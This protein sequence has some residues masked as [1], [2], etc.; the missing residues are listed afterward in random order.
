MMTLKYTCGLLLLISTGAAA[1][2]LVKYVQPMAG[3]ASATTA[4][5]LKHGS[6]L[7]NFANTIPAVTAP[8][9]MT[10]WT[11]QTQRTESKCIPPYYHK[12][13][14]FSGFRGSHWLSGS[15]TQD[16]GSFT[17]MPIT[18]H[19]KTNNYTASFTHAD[20]ESTP[21]LYKVNLKQYQL[22]GAVTATKRCGMMQ[23]TM[24]KADSLYLLIT[25]N[26]DYHEGFIK[27][28]Q[29]KGEIYGYNPAH[30]IYQGWGKPAGFSGYFV[31][32]FERSLSRTG[33]FAGDKIFAVDS[34]KNGTTIGAYA[35]F[36][37]NKG[38]QLIIRIGTSFT[39]IDGA[40]KNLQAEI[41]AFNFDAVA[42]AG[43]ATWEK[44]LSQI[45]VNTTN[46]RDKHIFYTAY[47]HTMQQPRLFNDVDG[48]YPRFSSSYKNEKLAK[49]NYYDD[50]SMWDIYRAEIPLFEILKPKL[51]NNLVQSLILK[52][53]QGGWM[54]I[55]PCWNSY[56]S[57][58]IGDHTTSVI[59]S[60][61]LKGIRDYDVNEAYQILRH[62]AFDIP[63]SRADYVEG[64]GRRA[65]DSYLK[66]K[67]IPLEDS[68]LDAFHKMEQVSRTLEYA[69]D[70]YAL[71]QFA[72][73]LKK[74][75]DYNALSARAGYYKNVFDGKSGFVRGKLIN[76]S[77]A[78]PFNPDKK[79]TYITEGTA[80]QYTFYVPQDVPGLYKLMGG[81]SK[82]ETALD[83]LFAKGEYWHGN[84]PGH[85]IPFMY[86]YTPS[87]WKTQAAVHKILAA[88][89][90]DGP[91][92]LGGNDDAGQMSAWYMFAAMG[93]YPVNPVSGEY[94]LCAPLFDEITISLP[95]GKKFDVVCH[96][97]GKASQYIN[98]VMLN[99]KPMPK[100]FIRY[101]DIMNGG[102]LDVYLQ[103][104]PDK[105]WANKPSM[106]PKGMAN[107]L[108]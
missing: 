48:V 53:K 28:D 65:L 38:E 96:K 19:L 14:Q 32:K 30:R 4:G 5:A 89:Y 60:A 56:T 83:S 100:S 91:G 108:Q 88:E 6:V 44:A 73:G 37:L 21:Y 101:S 97:T 42:N 82:L 55:F 46:E 81:S 11:P 84:E 18:G 106:Q 63:P 69:Y 75:A 20:E 12:D 51:V 105:T 41:P 64:K 13:D 3:T 59:S 29:Q 98:K 93:F 23:F 15:C 68:V 102:K 79:E 36:K 87:P 40:R 45:K 77:W 92:G 27:V 24:D 10:Q 17:V 78:T 94:L 107:N 22:Q 50:F 34:I 39:G 90:S 49:G 74:T 2:N 103:D 62:N 7:A 66:Y 57:E 95:S 25:P 35:G 33:T 70:D 54:P 71:A 16:Y 80:R 58:M 52:G 76:G 43:K 26:S 47:Y 72:N 31:I 85:Q 67:Y 86:N 1:Q 104:K 61:Y 99:G 8:F 9:G